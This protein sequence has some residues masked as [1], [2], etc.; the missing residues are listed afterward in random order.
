M[1][2]V[3]LFLKVTTNFRI[4]RIINLTLKDYCI[5]EGKEYL[6]EEWGDIKNLLLTPETVRRG[7][8]VPCGGNAKKVIGG[9]HR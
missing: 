9:R 5:K 3:L 7:S 4:W 1:E 6:L 2:R 8:A